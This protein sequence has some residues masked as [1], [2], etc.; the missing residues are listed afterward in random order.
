MMR[1]NRHLIQRAAWVVPVVLLLFW[2]VIHF[3]EWY[4]VQVIADPHDLAQYPFGSSEGP[5]DG[6]PKYQSVET[7]ARA[8]LRAW[9]PCIPLVAMFIAGGRKKSSGTIFAAY[10]ALA[11]IILAGVGN[12]L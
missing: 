1:P 7:Y 4:R 8:M 3:F 10:L 11:I 9:I 5:I 6:D 12:V 2:F